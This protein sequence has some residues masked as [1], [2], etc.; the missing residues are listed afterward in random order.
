MA[1]FNGLAPLAEKGGLTIELGTARLVCGV[2][3]TSRVQS[4]EAAR[5]PGHAGSRWGVA[6]SAT[7]DVR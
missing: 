2:V 5:I 7:W 4:G 6:V 3:K 1:R